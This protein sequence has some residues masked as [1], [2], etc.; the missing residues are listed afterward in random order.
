V[1]NIETGDLIR[2]IIDYRVWEADADGDIMPIDAVW[3]YGIVIEVSLVDPHSIVLVR[4]DTG[5]HYVMHMIHDGFQILSKGAP[6]N[7][8]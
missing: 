2:W 3:A 1:E 6:H 8:D 5:L 4:L 7:E